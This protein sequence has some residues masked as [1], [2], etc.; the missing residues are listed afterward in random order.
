MTEEELYALAENMRK[1][2]TYEKAGRKKL[3]LTRKYL[4]MYAEKYMTGSLKGLRKREIIAKAL[5]AVEQA[6][7]DVLI[8]GAMRIPTLNGTLEKKKIKR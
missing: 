7:I 6:Q 5:R 4:C 1:Y 8:E 3:S 2:N